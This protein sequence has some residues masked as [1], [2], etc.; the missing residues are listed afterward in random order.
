MKRVLLSI[1]SLA[2]FSFLMLP[3]P[4]AED[5]NDLAYRYRFLLKAGTILNSEGIGDCLLFPYYDVRTQDGISQATEI[6]IENTSEYGIAAKLR[7]REWS[8]GREV[9]ST[10]IWIP[11]SGVWSGK[12]ELV[13]D[14]TNAKLTSFHPVILRHDTGAFYVSQVLASGSLFPVLK[15]KGGGS[16]FYG[17]IEVIGEEKTSPA[18]INTVVGRL[19]TVR[20]GR[21]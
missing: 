5:L 8:H 19:G 6:T 16:P 21:A 4:G 20:R 2:I 14:G 13:G 15:K 1:F 12:I 9:F 18:E 7:V 3:S 11:S 10:D 17:F